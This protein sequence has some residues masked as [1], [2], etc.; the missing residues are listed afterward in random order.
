MTA[1]LLFWQASASGE[2]LARSFS[3]S[4][5][6]GCLIYHVVMLLALLSS[7]APTLPPPVPGW[8]IINVFLTEPS[9][10][11]SFVDKC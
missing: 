11:V 10:S 4:D 6:K 9:S 3:A 5:T 2:M 7:V 8:D 1:L